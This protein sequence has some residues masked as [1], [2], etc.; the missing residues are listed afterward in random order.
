VVGRQQHNSRRGGS[1][2]A[3]HYESKVLPT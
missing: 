3:T 1:M 2:S